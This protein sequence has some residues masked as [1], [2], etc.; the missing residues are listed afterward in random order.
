MDL[1]HLC[2]SGSVYSF[3]HALV[4]L[5]TAWLFEILVLLQMVVRLLTYR[6]SAPSQPPYSHSHGGSDSS[7]KGIPSDVN[8]MLNTFLNFCLLVFV[9]VYMCMHMHVCGMW[10]KAHHSACVD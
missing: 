9:D 8:Y 6:C 1:N 5:Q 3:P 2:C 10:G 4:M 7:Q